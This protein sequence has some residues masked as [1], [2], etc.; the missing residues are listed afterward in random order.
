MA[1]SFMDKL[2]AQAFRAGIVRGTPEAQK[3]F[4]EKLKKVKSVNRQQLLKDSGFKKTSKGKMSNASLYGRMFMYFY[5][6]K[7]KKE[8]PYYDRFPLIFLVQKAMGGFHGLNLHYLP[9]KQRAIFFDRFVSYSNNKKFDESTKVKLKYNTL[10]KASK[11][12]FY[13]P[14]FKHYLNAHVRSNIVEIPASEWEAV[15]YLPTEYFVKKK[16]S[17]V[18]ADSRKMLKG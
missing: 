11:L 9:P 12:K 5:D 18:W 10:K 14:C 13:K 3:W 15:L 4:A 6:P 2:E 1:T 16:Q 7:L 17:A 8:L